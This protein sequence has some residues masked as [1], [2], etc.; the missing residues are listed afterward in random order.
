MCDTA[1]RGL[2]SPRTG[3]A[4]EAGDAAVTTAL[5][6]AWV[7]AGALAVFLACVESQL[8]GLWQLLQSCVALPPEL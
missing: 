3:L 7:V 8:R 6:L 2:A 5:T 4:P 1:M